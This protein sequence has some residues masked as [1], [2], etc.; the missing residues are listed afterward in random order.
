MHWKYSNWKFRT[1]IEKLLTG[2]CTIY[3]KNL[4]QTGYVDF[5]ENI[6]NSFKMSIEKYMGQRNFV[7]GSPIYLRKLYYLGI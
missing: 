3:L 7:M 4:M 6:M 1:E 5:M 2:I